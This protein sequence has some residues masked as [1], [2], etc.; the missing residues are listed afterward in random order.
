VFVAIQL[1]GDF[2][3]PGD[4]T[5][6][7]PWMI[8]AN[9]HDGSQALSI[10]VM[11]HVIRCTNI[12]VALAS[13]ADYRL[14]LIHRPGIEVRY[15]AAHAVVAAANDY[16]V[17]SHDVAAKLA[18]TKVT[19]GQAR[20][21]IQAAFPV[22]DRKADAPKARPSMF[23]GAW[24]NY[25][26]SPTIP[27]SLRMTAWGAIQA[28]TEWVDHGTSFRGG[29]VQGVSDRRA[30]ALMFGARAA[31]QKSAAV[32]AALAQARRKAHRPKVVG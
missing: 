28:V 20:A 14:R 31:S 4:S 16:L 18:A 3:V 12:L 7:T 15:V 30:E 22:S 25:Q 11:E 5:T 8:V 2:E 27:D 6:V 9:G 1:P 24:A 29:A 21:I 17:E 19:E 13:R 10:N 32:D 23:D 26:A